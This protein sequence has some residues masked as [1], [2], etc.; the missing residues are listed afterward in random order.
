MQRTSLPQP[1]AIQPQRHDLRA[2]LS[3]L[4]K[5]RATFAVLVFA[6]A[7]SMANST[8]TGLQGIQW[9][10]DTIVWTCD[11]ITLDP[12]GDP[13]YD[14]TCPEG[15]AIR[16]GVRAYGCT[17]SWVVSSGADLYI[18]TAGHCGEVGTNV[19]VPGVGAI[20]SI[21]YR[22]ANFDLANLRDW[23]FIEIDPTLHDLVDPTMVHYG[24]P[25]SL[26]TAVG[27]DPVRPPVPGD[28][29]LQYGHGRGFG[30]EEGTKARGGII[31]ALA[32]TVFAYPGAVGGGDSGSP[33]RFATG[34]AAGIVVAGAGLTTSDNRDYIPDQCV[35]VEL[36]LPDACDPYN[37]LCERLDGSCAAFWRP[38]GIYGV[39][40][41]TRLDAALAAFEAW[42]GLPVTVLEGNQSSVNGLPLPV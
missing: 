13:A 26:G 3:S 9:V 42:L 31:A 28:A 8:S 11:E 19:S 32:P 18:A 1:V 29:V 23:A 24:G 27:L 4:S 16:P 5:A 36:L 7:G 17:L 12:F 20:G 40:I 25:S 30:E 34:E 33:V 38:H 6:A 41:A 10:A 2:P 21:V 22:E 14:N 15:G 35:D 39:V 37:D